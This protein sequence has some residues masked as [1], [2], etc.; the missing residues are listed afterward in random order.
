MS[1]S[2]NCENAIGREVK[3]FQTSGLF[4]MLN[5]AAVMLNL[6]PFCHSQATIIYAHTPILA[7]QQHNFFPHTNSSHVLNYCIIHV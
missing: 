1:C 5:L 4:T 3:K 2:T 6:L 7:T